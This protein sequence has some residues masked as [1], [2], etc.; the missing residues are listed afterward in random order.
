MHKGYKVISLLVCL[1]VVVI[2]TMKISRSQNLGIIIL[3]MTIHFSVI[4]NDCLHIRN[5]QLVSIASQSKSAKTGLN[6]LPM[7]FMHAIGGACW[8]ISLITLYLSLLQSATGS[9]ALSLAS[10]KNHI[11]VV[12][13]LLESGAQ[14]NKVQHCK[15]YTWSLGDHVT[16]NC[17]HCT[18]QNT[19]T[20]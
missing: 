5:D 7:H 1:S 16:L 2:T 8:W 19:T 12:R 4:L 14:V 6:A 20:L 13:L 15:V 17:S 3:V 18:G 11:N 10:Q 9:T